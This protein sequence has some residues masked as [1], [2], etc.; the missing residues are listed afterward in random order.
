MNLLRCH[1]QGCQQN[2][3]YETPQHEVVHS[4]AVCMQCRQE[5]LC[6]EHLQQRVQQK[7]GQCRL[8]RS[9]QWSLL[10]LPHTRFSPKLQAFIVQNGGQLK[11]LEPKVNAKVS[12]HNQATK[13]NPATKRLGKAANAYQM[14]KA[15]AQMSP[16][17]NQSKST[18]SRTAHPTLSSNITPSSY[19]ASPNHA[20]PSAHHDPSNRALQQKS[21]DRAQ[22]PDRYVDPR[23][24]SRK[25]NTP[26][27][28]SSL[29]VAA[30]HTHARS[31]INLDPY[32]PQAGFD[33]YAQP[34]SQH[35]KVSSSQRELISPMVSDALS[36]E[37][38]KIYPKVWRLITQKDLPHDAYGLG[39]GIAI[40][41]EDKRRILM[42]D[43][44]RIIRNLELEGKI[45]SITQSPRKRRL[46][47]ERELHGIKE[48]VWL[49]GK[50]IQGFIT[51]PLDDEL[52]VFGAH[53]T[54]DNRFVYMSARPDGRFDMREGSFSKARGIQSRLLGSSVKGVP[55]APICSHR[56]Q[57]VFFFKE[58]SEIGYVPVCRRLSDGD[59]RIMGE[60]CE[61][62]VVLHASRNADTI[63]WIDHQ[64]YIW[65]CTEN[66]E[67]IRVARTQSHLLAVAQDGHEIAWISQN[68]LHCYNIDQ[69]HTKQWP[70]REEVLA[71]GWRSE[72][73]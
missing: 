56:S 10:L 57:R 46:I 53:F 45:I 63:A 24:M 11:V 16:P 21:H 7:R 38:Q 32:P 5:V 19:H 14:G 6:V 12:T 3:V 50:E 54:H 40:T 13:H 20:H 61:M 30:R 23:R 67:A 35:A 41:R 15:T 9:Q 29:Q 58:V 8:C 27:P 69:Q 65:V 64:G 59:D 33:A 4:Y 55:L 44:D 42:M 49:N 39:Q 60:L 73:F 72:I 18:A 36:G 48:L 62:P 47:I 17:P 28:V 66:R 70:V 51:N 31:N 71:I 37:Q 22:A 68:T 26:V 34:N 52:P 1:Q 2:L 25:Q 43:D